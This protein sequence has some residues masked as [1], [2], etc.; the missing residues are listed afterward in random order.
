MRSRLLTENGVRIHVLAFEPGD[1]V[2]TGLERF[3]HDHGVTSA[4]VRAIGG[5]SGATLAFF[6]PHRKEFVEVP[7]HEQSEVVSLLGDIALT[8]DVPTAHVHAALGLRS[9]EMRGGHLIR[10]LV[11]PTLELLLTESPA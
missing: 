7:V 1:E 5:F 9:G 6:D 8:D 3:A 11:C 4:A 10:G 2:I